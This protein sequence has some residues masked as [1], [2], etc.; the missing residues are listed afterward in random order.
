MREQEVEL[1][2]KKTLKVL[3][4]LKDSKAAANLETLHLGHFENEEHPLGYFLPNNGFSVDY[5]NLAEEKARDIIWTIL[6]KAVNLSHLQL[7]GKA[8]FKSITFLRGGVAMKSAN[9]ESKEFIEFLASRPLLC[10]DIRCFAT[11]DQQLDASWKALV[12][13]VL[14]KTRQLQIVNL[15]SSR[16]STEQTCRVLRSFIHTT[17][18]TSLEELHLYAAFNLSTDEACKLFCTLV[19][20]AVNLRVVFVYKPERQLRFEIDYATEKSSGTVRAIDRAT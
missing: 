13:D 5:C 4:A 20:N 16:L 11:G 2:A 12:C 15:G 19:A 18:I 8:M 1:N 14:V 9:N 6:E 3:T 10:E 17:N 7:P